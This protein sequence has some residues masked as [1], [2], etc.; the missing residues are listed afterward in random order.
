MVA[1]V[2]HTQFTSHEF[3]ITDKLKR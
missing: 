3:A 2:T 1:G